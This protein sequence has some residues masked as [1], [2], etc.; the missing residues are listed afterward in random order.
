MAGHPVRNAVA[1]VLL[2]VATTGF[3]LT[4]TA[5]DAQGATRAAGNQASP[6]EDGI[7]LVR[8]YCTACHNE[9]RRAGNLSLVSFD[10]TA[11]AD[12]PTV[13]E[14]ERREEGA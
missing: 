11:A 2:A 3:G 12:N 5:R 4:L 8:E 6:A 1:G 14:M 10:V 9:R 13:A 7:A